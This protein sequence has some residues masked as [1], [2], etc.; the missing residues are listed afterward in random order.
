MVGA[1]PNQRAVR[2]AKGDTEKVTVRK[3]ARAA[4]PAFEPELFSFLA[5][6]RANNNRDWFAANKERYEGAVLAPA[7]AFIEDFAPHLARISGHLRADPRPSGGS[8]FRIYRDTRFSKDKTPYKT[9]VGVHFRHELANDVHAPGFYLHLEPG[10]VF[11][12]GGVWRPDTKTTTAIREAIAGD[13]LGWR[14]ATR[15]KRFASRLELA[16]VTLKRPPLGFD[17]AHPLIDDLRRKDFFGSTS[18]TEQDACSA[19]LIETYA[20]ICQAA[21]P[22]MQFL[23]KALELPF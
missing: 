19:G 5:D 3:T 16:G 1:S 13:P 20:E 4:E 6:L 15:S 2:E 10:A 9:S 23:C 18:L 17:P 22:L 12:G 14:R 8:L 11:A 7:L 21:R